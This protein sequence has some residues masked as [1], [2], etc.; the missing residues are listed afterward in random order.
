MALAR[1]YN[2]EDE[3]IILIHDIRK[4]RPNPAK[5]HSLIENEKNYEKEKGCSTVSGQGKVLLAYPVSIYFY[6]S[7]LAQI[8][9]I[10]LQ[11]PSRSARLGSCLSLLSR[12]IG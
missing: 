11:S 3:L 1:G 2:A 8:L 9:S 5:L 10:F 12:L 4:A 7:E 6:E